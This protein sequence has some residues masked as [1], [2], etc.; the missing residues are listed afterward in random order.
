MQIK[1]KNWERGG[2]PP[3]KYPCEDWGTIGIVV[4]N[5]L[6]IQEYFSRGQF[7]ESQNKIKPEFFLPISFSTISPANQDHYRNICHVG[8]FR[9]GQLPRSIRRHPPLIAAVHGGT[10][11]LH[12][13]WHHRRHSRCPHGVCQCVR[14]CRSRSARCPCAQLLRHV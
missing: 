4:D 2:H 12:P 13:R 14:N 6:S 5:Y 8:R 10:R 9:P 11:C 7:R 3:L 1:T